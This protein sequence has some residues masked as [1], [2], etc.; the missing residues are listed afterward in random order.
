MRIPAIPSCYVAPGAAPR[1]RAAAA[2]AEPRN[3][4]VAKHQQGGARRNGRHHAARFAALLIAGTLGACSVGPS[5]KPPAEPTA[6]G[7]EAGWKAALPSVS[8]APAQQL[9]IGRKLTADW[10]TLFRSPALDAVVKQALAENPGLAAAQANLRAAQEIVTAARGSLYPQID[11]AAGVERQRQNYAAFGLKLPPT[12]FNTFSIGPS[13][14]YSLDP[15][16]KNRRLVEQRKAQADVQRYQR[17]A[18]YL[19][20]TGNVVSDALI[21]ASL[22]AQIKASTE[23]VAADERTLALARQ[24][25]RVGLVGDVDV[26]RAEAQ[27]AGDRMALPPLQQ[28]LSVVRHAF[29][30]LVGKAPGQ[31]KPPDFALGSLTL[32]NR[33]P[34]SLPS[35]LVH[36]RPDILAAEA[37]LHAASAAVGVATAALYPDITLTGGAE[38]IASAQLFTLAGSVWSLAAGLSAPLFHGGALTAQKRAAEA[39]YAAATQIYRQTVLHAFAQVAD[40][41]DALRHDTVLLSDARQTLKAADRALYLT[42]QNYAV[43]TI[44]LLDLLDAERVRQHALLANTRAEAQRYLDTTN[45]F[46]AMGG[47]WWN[48]RSSHHD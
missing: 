1:A 40:A 22:R 18:A 48:E 21:I 28:R 20:L 25:A 12:T 29:S 14:S 5:F 43:G 47:G 44:G 4:G 35:R 37:E 17:D 7:Y 11:F 33:I 27:L 9:V 10:W 34:V 41:L 3:A 30:S 46:L 26:A 13:V 19:A 31:W 8:G 39:N 16:G 36:R 45:L 15:F 6:T 32:P 24:R 23:V 2:L 42:R 38:Q